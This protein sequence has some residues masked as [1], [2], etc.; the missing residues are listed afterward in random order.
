MKPQGGKE[1]SPY[2]KSLKMEESYSVFSFESK[3]DKDDQV[4]FDEP[5][6]NDGQVAPSVRKCSHE[7]YINKS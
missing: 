3:L 6:L 7:K 2:V 4:N 1:T 5:L